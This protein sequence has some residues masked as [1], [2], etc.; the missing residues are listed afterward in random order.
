MNFVNI[1]LV[2][3]FFNIFI[4]SATEQYNEI[5]IHINID[6]KDKNKEILLF[7]PCYLDK[8]DN[9]QQKNCFKVFLN[10]KEIENISKDKGEFKILEQTNG[11]Y[12]IILQIN[13]NITNFDDL[14]QGSEI[15]KIDFSNCNLIYTGEFSGLL[16]DCKNL[17]EVIFGEG[18]DTSN[19]KDI[20]DPF[21]QCQNLKKVDFS[22]QKFTNLECIHNFCG[23]Q[24][25]LPQILYSD[26]NFKNKLC[27]HITSNYLYFSKHPTKEFTDS[28]EKSNL[29]EYFFNTYKKKIKENKKKDL[30]ELKK[31]CCFCYYTCYICCHFC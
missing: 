24:Q 2:L 13:K 29:K 26:E 31:N 20:Y 18:F 3:I 1:F 27:E 28:L 11:T 25:E 12:E 15:I 7:K 8:K 10:G 19:I 16:S 21:S 17:K 4:N 30:E 6:D 9:I 5:K 23:F 22:K 14:F